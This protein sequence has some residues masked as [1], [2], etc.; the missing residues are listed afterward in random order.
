MTFWEFLHRL[1]PGWPTTRGWYA[2]ALCFQT[3]G[4]IVMIAAFPE[5]TQDEFFKSIATAIVVTGWIG[6]AVAGRDNRLEREQIG[7]AQQLAQDL[8]DLQRAA[9]PARPPSSQPGELS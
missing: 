6:F 3:C 1:G 5:L 9:P 2:T 4:I 8:V 7:R